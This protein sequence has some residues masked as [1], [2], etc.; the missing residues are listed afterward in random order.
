MKVW[1]VLLGVE[2]E[3]YQIEG[4]YSSKEKAIVAA[5]AL[6][7]KKLK[8]SYA[9]KDEQCVSHHAVSPEIEEWIDGYNDLYVRIIEIVVQ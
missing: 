6:V 4:I 3:G 2:Y 8:D 1:T 9:P 7:I 5:K